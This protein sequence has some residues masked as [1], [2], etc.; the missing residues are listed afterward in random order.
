MKLV[1]LH[2]DN[3]IYGNIYFDYAN[4]TDKKGTS[5]FAEKM[6]KWIAKRMSKTHDEEYL[7]LT[8]NLYTGFLGYRISG[9]IKG[10]L[11]DIDDKIPVLEAEKQK[12]SDDNVK[13]ANLLKDAY[14]PSKIKDLSGVT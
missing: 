5:D 7:T 14:I 8:A 9:L 1:E 6:G 2:I 3:M 10:E 13:L 11:K 12:L 4:I